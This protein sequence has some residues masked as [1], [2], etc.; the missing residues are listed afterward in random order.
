MDAEIVQ[1]QGSLTAAYRRYL[2]ANVLFHLAAADTAGLT[3]VDYQASNLLE[4]D[5]PLSNGQLA[6]RLGLTSGATTRLVDRLEARGLARRTVDPDDRRRAVIAHTGELPADLVALLD[7]VR[8]PIGRAVDR[9]SPEQVDGLRTYLAAA[10][11]AF[12][13][14]A[15]AETGPTGRR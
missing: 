3:P 1:E 12:L 15:T 11:D 14:A 13:G 8:A 2:A 4:L 7:A 9:L 10:T 5:G 6:A